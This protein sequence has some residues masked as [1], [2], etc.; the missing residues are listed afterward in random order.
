MY[1][2]NGDFVLAKDVLGQFLDM[3]LS[4]Q[5]NESILEWRAEAL[6]LLK[7]IQGQ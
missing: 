7:K 5:K 6:N 4:S 1:I 2:E 3:E